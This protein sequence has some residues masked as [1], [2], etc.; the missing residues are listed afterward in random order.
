MT[1]SVLSKYV[2]IFLTVIQTDF[3]VVSLRFSSVALRYTSQ[4][5]GGQTVTGDTILC[6]PW[7]LTEI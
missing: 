7:A 3:E 2:R 1:E 4:I 6:G 5:R